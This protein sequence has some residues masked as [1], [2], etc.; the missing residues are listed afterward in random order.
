VAQTVK[1]IGGAYLEVQD[2]ARALK[3]FRK[4]LSIEKEAFASAPLHLQ[5]AY[6][7]FFMGRAYEQLDF[8]LKARSNY[9]AAGAVFAMRLGSRHVLTREVLSSHKF[10]HEFVLRKFLSFALVR[11]RLLRMLTDM[12]TYAD[13]C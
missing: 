9:Q 13:V 5:P 10:A 6:T 7:R 8:R 12:L 4:A 11:W 2:P 1:S 3:Y